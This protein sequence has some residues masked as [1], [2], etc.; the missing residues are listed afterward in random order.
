MLRVRKDVDWSQRLLPVDMEHLN[1]RVDPAGW[2][3]METFE[4]FGLAILNAIA[5]GELELVRAFGRAS[6]DWL[7]DAHPGLLAK[8]DPRESLMRFQVMRQSFFDFPALTIRNLTDKQASMSIDYQMGN[9]AE[10]AA[11][12]Q[13]M[14]FFERLLEAAGGEAVM[15]RF[16][17]KRWISGNET[18]LELQWRAPGGR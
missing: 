17:S 10:E 14:G 3:P 11:C 12:M 6:V 15:A 4:R 13:T 5:D 1:R 9:V 16:S 7:I 18:R 2:Y 8:G